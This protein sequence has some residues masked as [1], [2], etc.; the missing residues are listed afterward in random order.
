MKQK[1]PSSSDFFDRYNRSRLNMYVFPAIFGIGIAFGMVSIS[2]TGDMRGLMAS[3]AEIAQP[4]YDADIIM[5]RTD[6]GIEIILGKDADAVDTIE[7]RL[8]TSPDNT[9]MISSNNGTLIDETEGAYR[10]VRSYGGQHIA[11]GTIVGTFSI[12]DPTLPLALTD[13]EMTS[14]DARYSLTNKSE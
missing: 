7:F 14:G 3:V 1:T 11:A 4:V 13:T 5:Q 9:A 12:T 6:T 10:F 2:H 8:L